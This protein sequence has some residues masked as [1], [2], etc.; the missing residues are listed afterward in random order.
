[1][2]RPESLENVGQWAQFALIPM[3]DAD[4]KIVQMGLD[5]SKLLWLHLKDLGYINA[6][7]KV[8][9]HLRTALKDDT[10]EV[11][12]AFKPQK[13]EI[14]ETLRKLAGRLEIKNADERFQIKTRQAILDSEEFKALWD[15]IK[16]KTT[17]RVHFDNEKLIVD[18]ASALKDCPPVTKTRL[19]FRT[20]DLAIGRGG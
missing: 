17:Y 9:D 14:A 5:R 12:E 8:Q 18:C 3:H 10:L 20:V 11:P 16:H 15:R 13:M 6:Q 19:R 1:M 4:G 2:F 7:G